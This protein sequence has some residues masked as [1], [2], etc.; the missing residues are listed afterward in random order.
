VRIYID[1]PENCGST[2]GAGSVSLTNAG[3]I[4][5]LNADPTTLQLYV[6]G[7]DS[8]STSVSLQSNPQ[9]VFNL[10]IYAPRSTVS[11]NNQT[12][13]V[14][15]IAGK[16]ASVDNNSSITWNDKVAQLRTGSLLSIFKRQRWV[17]CTTKPPSATPDS[18]C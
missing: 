16:Q 6:V 8:A 7:S 5:N 3:S 10:V 15:A 2:T 13:I 1:A 14:G 12:R 17:E 18:G 11:V 4:V 9:A